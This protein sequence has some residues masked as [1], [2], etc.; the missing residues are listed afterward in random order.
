MNY[1]KNIAA[2]FVSELYKSCG[3]VLGLIFSIPVLALYKR[4]NAYVV[5]EF[6]EKYL[7]WKKP[8]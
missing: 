8:G 4:S 2:C 1:K 3:N 6:R 7:W 5:G